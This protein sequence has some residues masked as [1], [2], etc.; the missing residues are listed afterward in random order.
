LCKSC[1]TCF[2]FYCMFYFTCDRS[3]TIYNSIKPSDSSHSNNIT[4]Q[5]I[6][7]SPG[8]IAI[9]RVCLLARCSV[10]SLVRNWPP[11]A[12][13]PDTSAT[14]HF[15]AKT[16]RHHKIGAEV[17]GHFGTGTEVCI[18]HFGTRPLRHFGTKFKPKSVAEVSEHFGTN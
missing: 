18:G 15:G 17:S 6:I 4:Q 3:L 5:F 16:L 7:P 1:R 14:G 8:G 10:C 13:E 12:R 11:A 2:K 9:R